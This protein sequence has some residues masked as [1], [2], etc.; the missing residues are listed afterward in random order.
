MQ[1]A[2]P[3]APMPQPVQP[4][5]VDLGPTVEDVF[6]LLKDGVLRRFRI[7]I[8]ADSTIVGDESQERQD[9]AAFI[10]ATTNFVT[11]WGPIVQQQPLMGQLAGQLLLFGVRA[12]RVG[13]EL[14]ETIEETV[15][16]LGEAAKNPSPPQPSPDEQVKLEAVKT[17]TAAEIEKAQ[18]GVKQAQVDGE[19]KMQQTQLD[20]RA[21]LQE[22]EQN[23]RMMAMEQAAAERGAQLEQ[24]SDMRKH[25]LEVDKMKMAAETAKRQNAQKAKTGAR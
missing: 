25:A 1:Q 2:Q 7:D 9:R 3:G 24:E 13:R 20:A 5:K 6:G 19:A 22:H 23:A 17:K 18:I 14:E 15:D 4:E 12:F 16:K 10:E 11:A 8:E 21:S